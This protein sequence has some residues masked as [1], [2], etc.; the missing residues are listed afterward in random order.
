MGTVFGPVLGAVVLHGLAEATKSC[1]G[2]IPGIDLV[3]F[4]I[5]LILVIASRRAT[6]LGLLRSEAA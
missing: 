2:R 1:R 6:F 4:G 5:V 3:I